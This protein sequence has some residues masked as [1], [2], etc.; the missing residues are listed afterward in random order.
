MFAFQLVADALGETLAQGKARWDQARQR[1]G[2]RK[3]QLPPTT[4]AKPAGARQPTPLLAANDAAKALAMVLKDPLEEFFQKDDKL[5]WLRTEV[6][7]AGGDPE[8]VDAALTELLAEKARREADAQSLVLPGLPTGNVEMRL[9]TTREGEEV[10]GSVLDYLRWLGLSN[11]AD[12]W[13][14]WM[15][16]EFRAFADSTT[17]RN[18]HVEKIFPG[19]CTPTPFTNFAGFRLLTK[20]CLRKS[21]IAQGL[22]DQ[23]LTVLGRVSVGDQTLH[24]T[25]DANAASSSG[26]ARAFVLGPQERPPRPA[27]STPVDLEAVIRTC[28]EDDDVTPQVAE[29]RL[30]K[31]ALVRQLRESSQEQREIAKRQKVADIEKYEAET[32]ANIEELR[33]RKEANIEKLHAEKEANIEK[34]HAARDQA[35][36]ERARI[37]AERQQMQED[38][39]AL[40][41]RRARQHVH[42]SEVAAEERRADIRDRAAKGRISQEAAADMLGESRQTPI[43][44]FEKWIGTHCECKTPSRCSSVLAKMFKVEVEA[45]RHAKPRTHKNEAGAWNLYV[46][47]DGP[48]LQRLHQQLHDKRKGVDEN[49]A[50]LTFSGSSQRDAA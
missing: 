38:A 18:F 49:Q 6:R 14:H 46:E 26:E 3:L 13:S 39:E 25:L 4:K 1:L 22:Y 31:V 24:E 40:R 15:R 27:K 17:A 35:Q 12:E 45:G 9:R 2:R 5:A 32:S 33:A 19:Q 43:V 20:L 28:V 7:A 29:R 41:E 44:R 23:A 50:R 16:E 37:Q 36:A 48:L 8:T 34:L 10:L 47:H 30:A 21:K 11:A 42:D